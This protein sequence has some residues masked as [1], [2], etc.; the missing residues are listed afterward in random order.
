MHATARKYLGATCILL[1]SCADTCDDVEIISG[2]CERSF[3][4]EAD[5]RSPAVT[6]G[7]QW[8]CWPWK[9]CWQKIPASNGEIIYAG[10]GRGLFVDT[11]RRRVSRS[12][13]HAWHVRI[14]RKLPT[15]PAW[16]PYVCQF[17]DH[18]TTKWEK[19]H[20][21]SRGRIIENP[22]RHRNALNRRINLRIHHRAANRT[23]RSLVSSDSSA[24]KFHDF[25]VFSLS[26]S[27]SLFFANNFSRISL[28]GDGASRFTKWRNDTCA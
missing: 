4:R 19:G 3:S 13:K 21:S 10:V 28:R 9:K 16:S 8:H 17:Y 5:Y 11:S 7:W 12:R 18:G 1:L 15:K 25:A 23:R 27:L 26:L 24:R 2:D 14:S 22:T 20:R 6:H